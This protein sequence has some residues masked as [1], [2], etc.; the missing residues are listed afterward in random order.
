[1]IILVKII[2]KT[3]K[4]HIHYDENGEVIENDIR[5]KYYWH[6]WNEQRWRCDPKNRNRKTICIAY[7]RNFRNGVTLY[8]A[9]LLKTHDSSGKYCANKKKDT[10]TYHRYIATER[11][12]YYP[13]TVTTKINVHQSI[14]ENELKNFV[15]EFGCCDRYCSGWDADS[16]YIFNRATF[17]DIRNPFTVK[18]VTTKG[19]R[20][21]VLS[22]LPSNAEYVWFKTKV[23]EMICVYTVI[24]YDN[25]TN[26]NT[27]KYGGSIYKLDNYCE[28]MTQKQKIFHTNTAIQRFI[29]KP[30]VVNIIANN[31]KCLHKM[32]KKMLQDK[33]VVKST[34]CRPLSGQHYM[35]TNP[36]WM[37]L[38]KNKQLILQTD[39]LQ[40][41]INKTEL[42]NIS[43]SASV[44]DNEYQEGVL[45]PELSMSDFNL[46]ASLDNNVDNNES[47]IREVRRSQRIKN[48][49]KN[50]QNNY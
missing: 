6:S 4:Q 27:I 13:M 28:Y 16:E 33:G 40:T 41:D 25:K 34:E 3:M 30:I 38:N 5:V 22:L 12:Y 8:G 29:N 26:I 43:I 7:L 1:M 39:I 36:N 32:L 35:E 19:I 47:T 9:S 11:L 14:V 42:D 18:S 37:Y 23:R 50:I 17:V 44:G 48:Q 46:H 24:N 15:E 2:I 45:T 49:K 10:K 31:K 20:D 21:K